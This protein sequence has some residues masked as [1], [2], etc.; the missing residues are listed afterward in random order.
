[1]GDAGREPFVSILIPTR[2]NV[3]ELLQCLA[4]LRALDY[5]TGRLE[6]IV[7]DNGSS[8]ETSARVGSAFATMGD[9]GWARL[10]LA[11]SPRNLGAFGG[12]AAALAWLG[13]EAGFV[14]SLDDDV[15]VAP[16][17]LR[18]LVAAADA[19]AAAVG[20]RI[21]YDDAPDEVASA[22]GHFNRW[23]GTYHERRPGERSPCDFV[24]SC[25]CLLRRGPLE[26]VGGF[27][28]SYFTS[29][30]DVDLCLALRAHGFTVLYEP[31]AVIRH[32]VAR[33]GTR[34]PERVYYVYRNKLLVLRKHLPR[35][36][37]PLVFALYGLAWLP[38]ALLGSLLRHRGWRQA[39]LRAIV[40]GV[41]DGL[42]DRRGEAP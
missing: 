31:A 34:D 8:D 17:S 29:H 22:A 40:R 18:R 33:G 25:G 27:D 20:A 16:D 5:P 28:G 9:E 14:L 41:R 23:L 36:R 35:R 4:S 13:R 21:V 24:T 6:I 3:E 26:S 12:R 38:R 37:R 1:M 15:V 2:N 10:V 30:G 42:L 39:E 7:F 11:R 19:G 32:K